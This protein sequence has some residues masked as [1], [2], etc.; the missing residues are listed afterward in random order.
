MFLRIYKVSNK[1]ACGDVLAPSLIIEYRC[2]NW[3]TLLIVSVYTKGVHH[4]GRAAR[5]AVCGHLWAA[6]LLLR[7]ARVQEPDLHLHRGQQGAGGQHD[8]AEALLL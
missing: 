3:R 1:H 6:G 8:R 7:R 2:Q 5:A 4:G